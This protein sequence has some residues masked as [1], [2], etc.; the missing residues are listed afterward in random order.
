[1]NC[2]C[3]LAWDFFPLPKEM[4][5]LSPT[6]KDLAGARDSFSTKLIMAITTVPRKINTFR[7]EAHSYS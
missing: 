4:C 2:P 3:A 6:T 7:K 5:V 1:M